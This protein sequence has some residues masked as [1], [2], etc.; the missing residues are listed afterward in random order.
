MATHRKDIMVQA[1]RFGWTR[2]EILSGVR[3]DVYAK[4]SDR[5][6]VLF[7]PGSQVRFANLTRDNGSEQ[8]DAVYGSDRQYVCKRDRVIEWLASK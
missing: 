7:T 6:A 1:K 3:N 8:R 5:V 4:G 2:V